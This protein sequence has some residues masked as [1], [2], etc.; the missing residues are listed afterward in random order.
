MAFFLQPVFSV[1]SD[2][3][4]LNVAEPQQCQSGSSYPSNYENSRAKNSSNQ[5]Y[6]SEQN[7]HSANMTQYSTLV[8]SWLLYSFAGSFPD[9]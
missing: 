7:I 6:A 1:A 5:T 2:K 3:L 4:C 9:P 8:S